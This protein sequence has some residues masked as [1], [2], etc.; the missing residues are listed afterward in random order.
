MYI[1]RSTLLRTAIISIAF[2]GSLSISQAVVLKINS[3]EPHSA[4]AGASVVIAGQGFAGD[5]ASNI[6]FFGP[7]Q[8]SIVSGTT[9][10][11]T[12]TVPAGASFDPIT[13]NYG[14]ENGLFPPTVPCD[15]R[16]LH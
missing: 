15:L 3:V 7:V 16:G 12:V 1:R 11:L 14:R 4:V 8:A 13:V 9:S 2:L 10:A 6:V 5:P